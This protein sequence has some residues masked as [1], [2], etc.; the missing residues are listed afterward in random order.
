VLVPAQAAVF[1]ATP[2]ILWDRWRIHDW[3]IVHVLARQRVQLSD[4]TIRELVK[5]AV[6]DAWLAT[7]RQYAH[8]EWYWGTAPPTLPSR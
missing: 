5:K 1:V 7:Q 3:D 8:I 2:V 6:F 4:N